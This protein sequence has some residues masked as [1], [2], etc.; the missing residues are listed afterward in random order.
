VEVSSSSTEHLR[1]AV[2]AP[3]GAAP[4]DNP[5][6]IAF[7]P[8]GQDN[9]AGLWNEASWDVGRTTRH[10][11][12][13]IGPGGVELGPGTYRVRVRVTEGIETPVMDAG[14]LVVT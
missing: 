10:A 4:E 2:H 7:L 5:V 3:A 11:Q 8:E 1:V 12:V 6:L 14:E 13:L 9:P